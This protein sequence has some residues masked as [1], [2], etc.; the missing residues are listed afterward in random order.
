MLDEYGVTYQPG[1]AIEQDLVDEMVASRWRSGRLS[2]IVTSLLDMQMNQQCPSVQTPVYADPARP[3][4]IAFRSMA[5]ESKA[6]ALALRYESR[7][8]RI[9]ERAFATLRE[10]QRERKMESA[11]TVGAGQA[12]P[13][14]SDEGRPGTETK[15]GE[16]EQ[17]PPSAAPVEQCTPKSASQP[18]RCAA[19]KISTNE[20]RGRYALKTF[21]QPRR[22]NAP[23]GASEA[24]RMIWK[25]P[26]INDLNP[27]VRESCVDYSP[28]GP[29]R[30]RPIFGHILFILLPIIADLGVVCYQ[31]TITRAPG[32]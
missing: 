16:G 28:N 15:P 12:R 27:A 10:L 5:D 9:H 7:L 23:S 18:A 31:R 25:S 2:M 30:S 1:N 6:L 11:P 14:P 21:H 17:A 20:P 24:T 29:D 13:S 32:V 8:R 3:V 4:A 19:K 22:R 26:L